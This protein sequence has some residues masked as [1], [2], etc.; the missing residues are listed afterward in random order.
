MDNSCDVDP[1]PTHQSIMLCEVCRLDRP[2][3][4]T[5]AAFCADASMLDVLKQ[6]LIVN[7]WT[8]VNDCH[9]Y[10]FEPNPVAMN[11]Y[12]ISVINMLLHRTFHEVSLEHLE[13]IV[14]LT[15][16]S[17]FFITPKMS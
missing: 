3:S 17:S 7:G 15:G 8:R 14:L 5:T 4:F 11:C 1:D 10:G 16:P 6:L 9:Y 12:I 2:A 13:S